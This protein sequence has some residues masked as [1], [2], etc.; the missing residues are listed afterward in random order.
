MKRVR[1][2]NIFHC[3]TKC[4]QI[5]FEGCCGRRLAVPS[6]HGGDTGRSNRSFF[7]CLHLAHPII[8][9]FSWKNNRW[10]RNVFR[11]PLKISAWKELHLACWHSKPNLY[12]SDQLNKTKRWSGR[13]VDRFAPESF[14]LELQAKTVRPQR[15]PPVSDISKRSVLT[16]SNRP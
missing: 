6:R 15:T 12:N 1:P 3:F 11:M 13:V 8:S 10:L 16:L 14:G 9:T 7:A 5:S 4:K 2:P